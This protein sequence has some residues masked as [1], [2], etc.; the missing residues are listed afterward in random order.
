[1]MTKSPPS[2][3]PEGEPTGL[4]CWWYLCVSISPEP[5]VDIDGLEVGGVAALVLEVTLPA[6]RVD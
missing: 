2:P 4:I 6:R 5:A 1:M 3:A